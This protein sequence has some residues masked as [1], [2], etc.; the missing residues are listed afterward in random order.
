MAVCSQCS[1]E[2]ARDAFSKVQLRK[3]DATRR[4]KQCVEAEGCQEASSTSARQKKIAARQ[5]EE[6]AEWIKQ[7]KL[8]EAKKAEWIQQHGMADR[9]ERASLYQPPPP[10]PP[11]RPLP[12]DEK[13][14]VLNIIFK[15]V[16]VIQERGVPTGYGMDGFCKPELVARL[17]E[18][19]NNKYM[20][21]LTLPLLLGFILGE[22]KIN[23]KIHCV[24]CDS[25]EEPLPIL[26]WACQYK[27]LKAQYGY[28]GGDDMIALI[29]AAGADVS[30]RV[31]NGCN[32]LFWAVKYSSPQAVGLLLDAG[33][34]VDDRD[35]FGQTIWKN[36]TERPDPGI[37][38]VLIERCNKIIPVDKDYIPVSD[39]YSGGGDL[40]SRVLYT[41]PDN[42][43]R[44]YVA[45]ITYTDNPTKIPISWQAVGAPTVDDMA[46]A[47]VRVLQAGARFSQANVARPDNIDPLAFVTHVDSPGSELIKKV[48]TKPQLDTAR[49]L[50]DVIC[51]RQL[52]S[53]IMKEVQSVNQSY[54]P[55]DTCPICLTDMEP[56]DNPVTLYCGH[57]YCL[58]CIKAYGKAKLGGD[59]THRFSPIR[60]GED[61]LL[62]ANVRV[63]GTDKR[64][65][66][67]RRLL[68]GDLLDQ[69]YNQRYRSLVGMRLGIDRHEAG[70]NL[71]GGTKR[72]P[73]LLSDKQLQFECKI[74]IGK[75]EGRREELLEE[76]LRSMSASSYS[77]SEVTIGNKTYSLN[78]KSIQMEL[79]ASATIRV[80][81]EDKAVVYHAPKWG[82]VVVPIQV[83][84][85]PIL[86]SLSP[87][88]I[89]TVVPKAVV[90]SFGLKTKP[91][92]SS[93]FV[94]LVGDKRV[95]VAEV[96]DEFRFF[97]EDVEICLNN[98][99]VLKTEPSLMRSVQLGVDFFE[100][101]LWTRCSVRLDDDSFVVSD[102]GYTTTMFTKD[103][104]DELRYYSRDGKIC[105]VPFIHIR[106]HSKDAMMPQIVRL[107][108]DLS[109]QCGECQWCCRYFPC[110]GMLKYDDDDNNNGISTQEFRY[111][112]DEEC[113]SKG[114]ATR[115]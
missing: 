61:G 1:Q 105:R 96:V 90:K 54:S 45:I 91:I 109:A 59:L 63:E 27:F 26:M 77:G 95:D 25:R 46:T 6:E 23:E 86:A 22:R 102:G 38:K 10:P 98:A 85:V 74:V 103:Q 65:P 81:G 4:C 17:W 33:V 88:S 12:E 42:M 5:Q 30:V 55:G 87:N 76:L 93:Q 106:N 79:N 49:F 97:L 18:V 108:G 8:A 31:S 113:K 110:D 11:P 56:S 21:W 115:S 40:S 13:T 89:F 20:T 41:L 80:S 68:C 114:M 112:C 32:P 73:H 69:D 70:G 7:N 39:S 44:V 36:A 34:S 78:E 100:S 37:V 50:H 9:Y 15:A 24:H 60:V 83:K 99:V 107:P 62:R 94:D 111:Y 51:G 82:P 28:S 47:L 64:C 29:L 67:C 35:S 3:T 66:I 72:G 57:K 58:E 92:T 43:L 104:P 2:K 75:S 14:H 16:N 71:S 48:Y 84:G 52:P 53:E 19:C 101:A